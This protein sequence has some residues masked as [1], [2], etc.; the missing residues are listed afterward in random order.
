MEVIENGSLIGCINGTVVG[1]VAGKKGLALY[2]NGVDQYV[3]SGYQGN[4]Y[5][6]SISL[7]DYGWVIVACW[8]RPADDA[9]SI[10][11]DGGI[12][13]Y[14]R[15]L[16][17]VKKINFKSNLRSANKLWYVSIDLDQYQEN[18]IH[19]VVSWK[20]WYGTKMYMNRESH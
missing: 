12:H 6:W 16:I 18:W 11:I 19:I 10:I 9:V 17:A 3:D 2:T 7:C 5:L 4:T 8:M 15:V 14:E 13:D 1:L 20:P